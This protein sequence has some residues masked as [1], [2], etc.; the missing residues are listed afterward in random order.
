MLGIIALAHC[1]R[2]FAAYTLQAEQ[3][4][5]IHAWLKVHRGYRLAEDRDC[6]CE[7]ELRTIRTACADCVAPVPDYHPYTVSG[8]LN[9]DNVIDFA[10]AIVNKRNPKDFTLLVFN[11]PYN[12]ERPLPAFIESHIDMTNIGLFYGPPGGM[13]NRLLIG[14]FESE[15]QVLEPHGKGYRLR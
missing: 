5:T 10:V 2:A 4:K 12:S 11:G 3:Q 9:G 13:R 14:R 8:D 6:N 7:E 15:G 1:S